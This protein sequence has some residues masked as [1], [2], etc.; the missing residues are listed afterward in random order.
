[1]PVYSDKNGASQKNIV[2]DRMMT[3]EPSEPLP[4]IVETVVTNVETDV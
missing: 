4:G 2:R 1:M 3:I